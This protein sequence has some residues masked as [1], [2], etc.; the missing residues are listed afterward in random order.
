VPTGPSPWFPRLMITIKASDSAVAFMAWHKKIV[1]NYSDIKS[2][3]L[4]R[5]LVRGRRISYVERIRIRMEDGRDFWLSKPMDDI[6]LE[7]ISE[8]PEELKEK[9]DNSS[10]NE[11]KTYIESR[12]P[13][14]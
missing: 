2:I 10:F 5:E 1:A 8:R 12:M 13:I 9:F 3:K 7:K 14:C 11:L 4:T 6:D